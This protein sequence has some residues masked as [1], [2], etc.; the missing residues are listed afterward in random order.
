MNNVQKQ[1]DEEIVHA[2]MKIMD[3]CLRRSTKN[4]GK[5]LNKNSSNQSGGWFKKNSSNQSYG[6]F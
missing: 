4:G 1:Y 5:M 3:K 2:I 6:S